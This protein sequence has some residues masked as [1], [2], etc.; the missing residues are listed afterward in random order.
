MR[1]CRHA[2]YIGQDPAAQKLEVGAA[3]HLPF[4]KFQPVN[5][6]F[7]LTV[8]PGQNDCRRNCFCVAE[9]LVTKPVYFGHLGN[10]PKAANDS[11]LKTGQ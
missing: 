10:R 1:Q 11:H 4:H 8:A 9:K 3:V 6:P 7:H 2:R 5:L